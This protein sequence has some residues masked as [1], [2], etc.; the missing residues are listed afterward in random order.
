MFSVH[1]L[2]QH[3]GRIFLPPVW[4]SKR[5]VAMASISS[6]K[7]MAGAFSLASRKTSRTIR[8]PSPKYFWTNSEPTTRMKAAKNK[9]WKRSGVFLT[10]LVL[11]DENKAK[12]DF[13]SYK[14]IHINKH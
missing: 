9:E 11:N 3:P 5:F 13:T 7:M 14:Y 12:I 6:M 10:L 1:A 8:G 2:S 4:A